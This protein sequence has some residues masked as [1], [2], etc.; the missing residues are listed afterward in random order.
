[1]PSLL[2]TQSPLESETQAMECMERSPLAPVQC[3]LDQAGTQGEQ[4]LG[5][6]PGTS[7]ASATL[8]SVLLWP[9]PGHQLCMVEPTVQCG[10]NEKVL[11]PVCSLNL[12]PPPR[13]LALLRTWAR[14]SSS[15]NTC[16]AAL[17][18]Y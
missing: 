10:L 16:T 11:Q 1:M 13:S 15:K 7:S 14:N 6:A 2:V 3:P 18:G 17:S 9:S 4:S 5:L 8:T 12:S